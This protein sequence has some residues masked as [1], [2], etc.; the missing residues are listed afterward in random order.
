MK[1][2][3]AGVPKVI[4]RLHRLANVMLTYER[5]YIV[6]MRTLRD[7]KKLTGERDITAD[8]S[9]VDR[10]LSKLANVFCRHKRSFDKS[11]RM[12]ETCVKVRGEWNYVY[13]AVFK[14]GHTV[15]FL[16]RAKRDEIAARRYFEKVIEQD[17]INNNRHN[18]SRS[19][20]I[21]GKQ[22]QPRN[23]HHDPPGKVYKVSSQPNRS[24]QP[25]DRVLHHQ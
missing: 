21:A 10:L 20:R 1:D 25:D 15:D 14:E 7:R 23:A 18:R 2:L 16:L 9:I 11:W 8:H 12:E 17:G 5:G 13:R 4:K 6:D 3:S 24:E 19:R 22:N